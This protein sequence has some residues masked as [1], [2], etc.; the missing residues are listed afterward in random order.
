MN[1]VISSPAVT[2]TQVVT[3]DG[4]FEIGRVLIALAIPSLKGVLLGRDDDKL[5][6]IMPG[7]TKSE[8]YS[9]IENIT[10]YNEVSYIQISY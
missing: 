10:Q 7:F 5:T 2:D 6:L 1:D 9:S 8:I 4:I 3:D